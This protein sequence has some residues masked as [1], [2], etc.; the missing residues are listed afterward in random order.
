MSAK[1]KKSCYGE[2]MVNIIT[3]QLGV[4]SIMNNYIFLIIH[5]VDS[6]ALKMPTIN[7]F[8]KLEVERLIMKQSI[9]FGLMRQ[10]WFTSKRKKNIG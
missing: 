10:R 8:V 3:I 9:H 4:P 1:A 2:K 6:N 7:F 5:F